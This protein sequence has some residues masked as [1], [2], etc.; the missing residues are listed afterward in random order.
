MKKKFKIAL[1]ILLIIIIIPIAYYGINS[2][3]DY[4]DQENFYNTIKNVSDMENKSDIEHSVILNSTHVTEK[5]IKSNQTKSINDLSKEIKILQELDNNTRNSTYKEYI[6]L[7]IDR[8]TS[9]SK[10]YEQMC[11]IYDA[12][13][14]Y[15]NGEITSQK[16]YELQKDYISKEYDYINKTTDKKI[17]VELFLNKHP[18]MK[19]KFD[20]LKI[21]EDFLVCQSEENNITSITKN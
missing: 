5:E 20:E 2:Y 12:D 19:D 13:E 11:N 6:E 1:I 9:E 21:D 16:R 10:V 4:Q 18:D 15:E 14:R 3:L 7:E 8:M 17:E